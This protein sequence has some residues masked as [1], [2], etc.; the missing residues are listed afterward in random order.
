MKREPGVLLVSY[1]ALPCPEESGGGLFIKHE[2]QQVNSNRR[3]KVSFRSFLSRLLSSSKRW[4]GKF[5]GDQ[6]H[7]TLDDKRRERS[8]SMADVRK[9][10]RAE[11]EIER[12]QR[13]FVLPLENWRQGSSCQE[14]RSG[15]DNDGVR[16]CPDGK[17]IEEDDRKSVGASS[18]CYDSGNFSETSS[19][20]QTS[21]SESPPESLSSVSPSSSTSSSFKRSFKRLSS[22]FRAKSMGNIQ[23][24]SR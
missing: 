12:F 17:R 6:E 7:S 20:L 3:K 1:S 8:F 4:R 15:G 16:D 14:L 10:V 24:R 21:E 13:D 23:Q 18:S 5:K 2:S 19:F 11:K 9:V 22:R